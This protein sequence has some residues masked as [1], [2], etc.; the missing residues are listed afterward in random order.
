M[1]H[2]LHF[3]RPVRMRIKIAPSSRTISSITC[4]HCA[5]KPPPIQYHAAPNVLGV[6][7]AALPCRKFSAIYYRRDARCAAE[8]RKIGRGAMFVTIHILAMVCRVDLPHLGV[9][10]FPAAHRRSIR[11][12]QSG[13]LGSGALRSPAGS[14]RSGASGRSAVSDEPRTE[15]DSGT[16]VL[17]V[18]CRGRFGVRGH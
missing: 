17:G 14:V 2:T 12:R 18:F 10:R 5:A 16:S 11:Y 8:H 13:G 9:A 15:V 3:I 1:L 4:S 7:T 6:V